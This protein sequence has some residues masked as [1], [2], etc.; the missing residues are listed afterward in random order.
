MQFRGGLGEV[1]IFRHCHEIPQVTQFHNVS[2][3]IAPGAD[4]EQEETEITEKWL[5]VPNGA[6]LSL[7]APASRRRYQARPPLSQCHCFLSPPFALVKTQPIA[8]RY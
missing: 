4:F 1:Q 7:V 2:G 3:R 5:S 6:E 8:Q